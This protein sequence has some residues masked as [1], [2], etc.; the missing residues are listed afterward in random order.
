MS[1]YTFSQWVL[2][3]YIY[4]FLG[5]VFESTYVS[6]ME[7][8]PVNRGFLKGPFL[9]IYGSGALC[10]LIVT[11]PFRDN[12]PLMCLSGMAAATLLEYVTGAAMEKLFHVRYW[13]YT[14]KFL[15]IN[16]HICLMSTLCWGVMTILVVEVL[17]V[18]LEDLVL[19]ADEQVVTVIV[20]ALTPF[21]TAD[22]VTSFHTAIHLRDILIQWERINEEMEKL[23]AQ[24]H[25]MEAALAE[26][27]HEMEAALA[28]RR[29]EMETALV[30]RRREME[31]S[32]DERKRGLEAKITQY[33]E[34]L[35]ASFAQRNRE[36]ADRVAALQEKVSRMTVEGDLMQ[37]MHGKPIRGLLKRNPKAVSDMNRE[38]FAALKRSLDKRT[39]AEESA[40]P[41]DR[42]DRAFAL[43][44]SQSDGTPP[45]TGEQ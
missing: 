11:I 10:V 13:D 42:S 17:Q 4:C 33:R 28:Q 20:F 44:N 27:R 26:R 36:L 25:E 1:V 34:E 39:G 31:L 30:Q 18:F 32:Y 19:A 21:L 45:K 7:H 23:E 15:N 2:F 24:R 9:P 40:H 37:K 12:I 35:E 16:G 38:A 22:L 41:E 5:W 3:F 43:E 8:H 14:G 6:I 29:R